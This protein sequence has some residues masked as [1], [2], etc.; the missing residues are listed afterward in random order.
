MR[1]YTGLCR[2]GGYQACPKRDEIPVDG[3][4]TVAVLSA[5]MG[6]PWR[7][8]VLATGA[9][10]SYIE[11]EHGA[12]VKRDYNALGIAVGDGPGL[13]WIGATL[14]QGPLSSAPDAGASLATDR[15][16]HHRQRPAVGRTPANRLSGT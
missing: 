16:T 4:G 5:T 9:E 13:E 12:L 10:L 8:G 7:S 6:D 11:R 3:D 14:A 15:I 2:T 1:E